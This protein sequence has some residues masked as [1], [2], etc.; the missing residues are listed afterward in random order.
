M[1]MGGIEMAKQSIPSMELERSMNLQSK[2]M[3]ISETLRHSQVIDELDDKRRE[4][5]FTTL[6]TLFERI[7]KLFLAPKEKETIQKFV[8]KIRK[9]QD[10]EL[11][12]EK[13]DDNNRIYLFNYVEKCRKNLREENSRIEK[14]ILS[15]K[16]D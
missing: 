2:V 11:R 16:N 15:R 6:D 13:I 12:L 8:A 14:E 1:R 5:L 3:T 7:D 9:L 4:K 10:E